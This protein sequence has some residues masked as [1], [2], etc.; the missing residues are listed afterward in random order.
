MKSRFRRKHKNESSFKGLIHQNIDSCSAREVV[1]R[2][3]NYHFRRKKSTLYRVAIREHEQKKRTNEPSERAWGRKKAETLRLAFRVSQCSRALVLRC[4]L[5][6]LPPAQQ[7]RYS[8]LNISFLAAHIY[9]FEL[10]PTLYLYLV[11][12]STIACSEKRRIC[13]ERERERSWTDETRLLSINRC[14]DDVLALDYPQGS[15]AERSRTEMPRTRAR[16]CSSSNADAQVYVSANICDIQAEVR[17]S[18][19]HRWER[20]ERALIIFLAASKFQIGFLFF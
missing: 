6:F 10:P 11:V 20:G 4:S 9:S 18:N 14:C 13:I 1:R 17:G 3:P 16:E 2:K 5:L 8:S 15:W 7:L 12:A 19:E